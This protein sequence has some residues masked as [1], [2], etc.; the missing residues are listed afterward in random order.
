MVLFSK[1][2]V[3]EDSEP[4]EQRVSGWTSAG[5]FGRGGYQLDCTRYRTEWWLW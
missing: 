5:D 2:V 4:K 3:W 1:L